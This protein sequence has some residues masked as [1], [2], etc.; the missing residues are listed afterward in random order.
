MRSRFTVEAAVTGVHAEVFPAPSSDRNST[1]V[2]PC[3]VIA[4]EAP[5]PAA[6]QV[7]PLSD[8]VRYW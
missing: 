8:D 3:A 6:V 4:S 5:A 2:E 1:W 7:W